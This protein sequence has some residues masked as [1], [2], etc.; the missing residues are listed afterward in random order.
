MLCAKKVT[1]LHYC[2]AD[3][4][5]WSAYCLPHWIT[6]DRSKRHFLRYDVS[7]C[8]VLLACNTLD[9]DTTAQC[10]RNMA[11]IVHTRRPKLCGSY[12]HSQWHGWNLSCD[13]ACIKLEACFGPCVACVNLAYSSVHWH[14]P[15]ASMY[16][17]IR[18]RKALFTLQ[19]APYIDA[20]CM[21]ILGL[22]GDMSSCPRAAM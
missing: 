3:F 20:F 14:S 22:Y 16:G 17:D 21:Y 18:C 15:R 4:A 10:G 12:G 13:M 11:N 7:S 9:S 19:M 1:S 8:S 6:G 2:C 5:R